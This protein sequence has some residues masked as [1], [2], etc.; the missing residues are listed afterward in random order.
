M[1]TEI[2]GPGAR[3]EDWVGRANADDL[4]RGALRDLLRERGLVGEDE[5]PVGVELWSGENHGGPAKD[6]SLRVF[7]LKAK[8]YAEV[9]S[10]LAAERETIAVRMVRLDMQLADFVGLFKRFGVTL[11]PKGLD[12][13]GRHIQYHED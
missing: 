4:D 1:T 3:Y 7:L 8:D 11:S 10:L 12:L 9:V 13:H 6:P 5:F 2:F